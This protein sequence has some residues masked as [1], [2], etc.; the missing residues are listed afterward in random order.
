M[1]VQDDADRT[2]SLPQAF[3]RSCRDFA[4]L[5]SRSGTV[6][7]QS[8]CSYGKVSMEGVEESVTTCVPPS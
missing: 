3:D 8:R 4:K 2:F 5:A 7:A 1:Q 6:S